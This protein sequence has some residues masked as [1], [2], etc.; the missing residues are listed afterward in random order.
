MTFTPNTHKTVS[1]KSTHPLHLTN[2]LHPQPHI[3]PS[4][5]LTLTQ[6]TNSQQ[7]TTLSQQHLGHITMHDH[8]AQL[9]H[10][11][12]SFITINITNSNNH[13]HVAELVRSPASILISLL[14]SVPITTDYHPHRQISQAPKNGTDHDQPVGG[15]TNWW[16]CFFVVIIMTAHSALSRIALWC[17]P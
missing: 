15:S 4:P 9:V 13:F 1:H 16:I 11:P 10:A 6:T 2:R 7:H 17:I 12:R 8:H 5:T 14:P 3:T